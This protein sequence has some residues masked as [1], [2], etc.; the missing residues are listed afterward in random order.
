MEDLDRIDGTADALRLDPLTNAERAEQQDQHAA[1][2]VRQA[3]LQCQADGQTRGADHSDER[4]GFDPDHRC[5]ADQQQH[6]EHHAGQAANEAMQGRVHLTALQQTADLGGEGVD[7]PP[8]EQEGQQCQ[9]DLGAVLQRDRQPGFGKIDQIVD[10]E[11][12]GDTPSK[13]RCPRSRD[14]EES[15]GLMR[16]PKRGG[17]QSRK[18]LNCSGMPNSWP[19]SRA[20]ASC[21]SSRF[22]PVTRT[23]SP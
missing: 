16:A 11:V 2:E 12:H 21:R 15:E 23:C 3:A 17:N 8:A 9:H 4:G 14:T 22:L 13:D 18:L 20:M 10:G 1:G 5:H 19:R 7:Q 6:P